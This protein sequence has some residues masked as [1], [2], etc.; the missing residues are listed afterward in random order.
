MVVLGSIKV[1]TSCVTI[2]TGELVS[3]CRASNSISRIEFV[4]M[5]LGGLGA[6]PRGLGSR[7][8]AGLKRPEGRMVC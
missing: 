7:A 1:V 6:R 8:R 4:L 3:S 2:S 5:R